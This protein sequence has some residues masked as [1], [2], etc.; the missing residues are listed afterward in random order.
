MN[1]THGG[2]R[3][4]AGRKPRPAKSQLLTLR[5]P[6]KLRAWYQ[7]ATPAAKKQARHVMVAALQELVTT[8]DNARTAHDDAS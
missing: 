1:A 7:A 2:K 6:P 3:S 5:V 8:R 4:G